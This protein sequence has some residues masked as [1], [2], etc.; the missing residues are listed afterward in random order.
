MSQPNGTSREE[1]QHQ[2]TAIEVIVG[3]SRVTVTGTSQDEAVAAARRRLC[4]DMPRMWDVI[5]SLDLQRFEV[6]ELP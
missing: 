2:I 5:Q 6:R 3:H 4:C 1:P